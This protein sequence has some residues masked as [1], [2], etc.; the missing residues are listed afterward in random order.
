MG[1]RAIER[2]SW[3]GRVFIR[4]SLASVILAGGF[5][6]GAARPLPLTDFG[7]MKTTA[8]IFGPSVC[9]SSTEQSRTALV[10]P[11]AGA[12]FLFPRIRWVRENAD[13][14]HRICLGIERRLQKGE[15]LWKA[16]RRASWY[17]TRQTRYYRTAPEIR[18]PF[19]KGTITRAWYRWNEGGKTAAAVALRYKAPTKLPMS[20]IIEL[21]ELT[22]QPGVLSVKSAWRMMKNHSATHTAYHHAM[23]VPLREALM[24]MLRARRHALFLEREARRVLNT[25]PTERI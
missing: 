18:V 16:V 25:T 6:A 14:L 7:G 24:A 3:A 10:A 9:E 20:E 2:C 15:P 22:M 4:L 5:S 1:G 19:T 21:A 11:P 17:Y 8:S 12:D 23:P 13:R